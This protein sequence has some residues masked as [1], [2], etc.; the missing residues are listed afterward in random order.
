[1]EDLFIFLMMVPVIAI[2]LSE[3]TGAVRWFIRRRV[4]ALLPH[5]TDPPRIWP[6][7]PRRIGYLD[8]LCI[9]ILYFFLI[10]LVLF[11]PRSFR[12]FLYLCLGIF[13]LVLIEAPFLY[14]AYRLHRQEHQAFEIH[15]PYGLLVYTMDGEQVTTD[16]QDAREIA[17]VRRRDGSPR[18]EWGFYFHHGRAITTNTPSLYIK[19][20]DGHYLLEGMELRL[21]D[22]LTLRKFLR[23]RK[24]PFI[25]DYGEQ[26]NI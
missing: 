7:R 26:M 6:V 12:S 20:K 10:Y 25:D 15:Q 21:E 23:A 2:P 11:R 8:T 13:I 24:I 22:Y 16:W 3:A 14:S 1:M 17:L 9:I 18:E 4:K 19:G 5:I